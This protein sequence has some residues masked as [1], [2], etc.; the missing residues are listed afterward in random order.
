MRLSYVIISHNRCQTLLKTLALLPDVTPLAPDEWDI[1]VVDNA[2]TDG[3]ADAVQQRFGRVGLIRNPVNQGMYARNHAFAR[4]G[5][6]FVI[7]LDDDSYPAEARAVSLALGHMELHPTAGALVAKVVL[8]DGSAEAPALPGVVMGGATCYRKSVLDQIGGFRK[9]FF[10]QAEEYDLSFRIWGA[11]HRVDR[12]EDIVFRHDKVPGEGRTSS[13]VRTLDL[14]NNLIVAQRYL[15]AMLRKIYWHDWR[16]RYAALARGD[17]KW[18]EIQKALLSAR[19]WRLREWIAGR[20]PL[21]DAA[22]ENIFQFRRQATAI[23]DWAR[24]HSVWR[25][26]LADFGKNIWP[27]YNACRSSGLQLRCIADD[28]PAFD[29]IEY[30]GLPIVPVRKAFEGG[31][32]DGVILTNI[33]PAQIDAR[34]K[35][36]GQHF[37]GPVLRLWSPPRTAT[38]VLV[39]ARSAAA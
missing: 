17:A 29:G 34:L 24:R 19:L 5:G 22:L 2:S 8:P 10:R 33:N 7:C 23:G 37:P 9:E 16:L 32:I 3:S 30:R 6:Q 36:I 15:P 12:R 26:V 20:P 21:N 18:H 38:Q 14:R 31:G 11:G 1:W 27:A 13:L 35:T 4:C 39:D 28:N 25:V